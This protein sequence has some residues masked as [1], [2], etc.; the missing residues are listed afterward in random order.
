MPVAPRITVAQSTLCDPRSNDC[1]NVRP[2]TAT[3]KKLKG[4]RTV[5]V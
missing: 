2:K 4:S 1:R 5:S 3:A